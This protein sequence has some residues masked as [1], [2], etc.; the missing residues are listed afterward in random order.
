MATTCGIRHLAPCL[1]AHANTAVLTSSPCSLSASFRHVPRA[2]GLANREETD[3][4]LMIGSHHRSTRGFRTRHHG[5]VVAP[6]FHT[7]CGKAECH[8][9]ASPSCVIRLHRFRNGR[10]R[11][12]R[13]MLQFFQRPKSPDMV[14]LTPKLTLFSSDEPHDARRCAGGKRSLSR[15]SATPWSAG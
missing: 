12:T 5:E 6:P 3:A 7:L 8:R 2:D 4:H 9:N 15:K 1:N 14:V 13:A 11:H 10:S